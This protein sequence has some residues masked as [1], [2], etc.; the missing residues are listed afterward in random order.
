MLAGPARPRR[1]LF[2]TSA[3]R[4]T[5]SGSRRNRQVPSHRTDGTGAIPDILFGLAAAIAAPP[6]PRSALN[7]LRTG[8]AAAILA[9][10]AAGRLGLSH[11]ALDGHPQPRAADYLRRM[12]VTHGVLDGR[13]EDL[14]RIRHLIDDTHAQIDRPADR[15]LI[16]AY[17]TWRVLRRLRRRAQTTP[18]P[19]TATNHARTNL[20]AAVRLLDWLD[21][22][23]TTLTD[24]TQA[25]LDAWAGHGPRRLLRPRLHPLGRRDQPVPP[26]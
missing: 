10:I 6:N 26:A 17:A 7:W 19:R 16:Q 22:R 18:G 24:A 23:G 15:R 12:L 14:E 21:E 25:D 5:T 8:A 2:H 4:G 11:D 9:D 3:G 13:D 20:K 1:A